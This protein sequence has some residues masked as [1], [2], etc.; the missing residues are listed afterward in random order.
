MLIGIVTQINSFIGTLIIPA[1]VFGV[2]YLLYK[3]PPDRWFR[4]KKT[5]SYS[6]SRSAKPKRRKHSFR[7][8]EG[9][10]PDDEDNIPKYH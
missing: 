1:I 5:S 6:R 9:S 8:I 7:V 2:I 4:R 3:F 10:K